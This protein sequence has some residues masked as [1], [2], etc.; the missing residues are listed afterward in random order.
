MLLNR[1]GEVFVG[2]RA[3]TPDEA[4]QMP[5]GGIDDGEEPRTAA[6]REL[7]EEIGVTSV[8]IVAESDG[9]LRYDLP[10]ALIGKAWGGRWRGQRQKWFVMRFTG[11]DTEIDLAT[12]HPEFKEWKWVPVGALPALVVS[13]KRQVYLDLLAEFP[14]LGETLGRTLS[15]LL[16][17]PVIRTAMSADSVGEDALYRL[18]RRVAANLRKAPSAREDK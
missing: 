16:S 10:D 9:W 3:D 13:F 12:E 17:D 5:Q 8:T 4:W 18:L 7:A 2:R 15:D 14:E 6:L 1:Q 11:A